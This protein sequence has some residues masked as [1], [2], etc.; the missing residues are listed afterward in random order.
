MH[1]GGAVKNPFE[2]LYLYCQDS[3]SLFN[4]IELLV[5][6]LAFIMYFHVTLS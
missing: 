3:T 1:G 4:S 6:R 2:N 5:S